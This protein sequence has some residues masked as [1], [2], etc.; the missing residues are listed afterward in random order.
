MK[1]QMF[2]ETAFRP[3]DKVR[4]GIYNATVCKVK[5]TS[6]G[7]TYDIVFFDKDDIEQ[8]RDVWDWQIEIAEEYSEVN[9]R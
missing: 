9:T 2:I 7:I 3:R 1:R 5:I 8:M 6:V 4:Y